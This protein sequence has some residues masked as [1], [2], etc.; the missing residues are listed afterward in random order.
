MAPST[1]ACSTD[2]HIALRAFIIRAGGVVNE[3][4]G[5]SVCG[6]RFRMQGQLIRV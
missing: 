2:S 5:L 3:V 1:P 6:L 4:R